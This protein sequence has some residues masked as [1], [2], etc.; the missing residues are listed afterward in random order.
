[1]G[2]VASWKRRIAIDQNALHEATL[3][4]MTSIPSQSATH[5]PCFSRHDVSC[6]SKVKAYLRKR[7]ADTVPALRRA[8]RQAFEQV[9]MEDI[10][11]SIR[12]DTNPD[13]STCPRLFTSAN[14]FNDLIP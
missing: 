4:M 3:S 9:T 12:G 10:P 11:A 14:N 1:M 6:I 2:S 5:F 7:Q 8:L 13:Y